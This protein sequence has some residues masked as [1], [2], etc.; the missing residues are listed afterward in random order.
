MVRIVGVNYSDAT[1]DVAITYNILGQRTSMSDGAGIAN[2]S[3]DNAGRV[4]AVARGA[5]SVG[6]RWNRLGQ[7]TTIVYPGNR[8]VARAYDA[9]G[10]L[11]GVT[12]WANRKF[13]FTYDPDGALTQVV[14][15]NAV[16][17][18]YD[19]D[20][21]GQTTAISVVDQPGIELLELA[22]SYSDAGLLTGQTT[23]R[24]GGLQLSPTPAV[25]T[26]S[27]TWD[28]LAR[29]DS[30]TGSGAGDVDYTSAGQVSTLPDGS[31]L[32]YDAAGQV[33]AIVRAPAIAGQVPEVT[34]LTYDN[35]GNRDTV[36]T[37]QDLRTLTYNLAN[38]LTGITGTSSPTYAYTYDGDGLRTSISVAGAGSSNETFV[39]DSLAQVPALLQDAAHLFVYGIGSTPLAQIDDATGTV[40][41]LHGDLLG[42][43]RVATDPQG[44]VLGAADYSPFGKVLD[45]EATTADPTLGSL[46][47]VTRF[48]YAGEYTDDTGYIY[49][50]ARYYDPSTAQFLSR[51]R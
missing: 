32:T 48:G 11:T 34:S 36:Q 23:I 20:D 9:V 43:I 41:Y 12:D 49:L 39:W 8:E 27:Y 7:L 14:Y 42:S 24:S 22:Y 15:P 38:Q 21:A 29:L 28:P 5:D 51:T 19:V 26:S 18:S 1:P 2:Y 50:R 45:G 33:T 3:Y 6:Y 37:D 40:S 13:A 46:S 4:T 16:K 17:T 30:I 35:R 10:H 47:Q 31:V 44:G 25:G